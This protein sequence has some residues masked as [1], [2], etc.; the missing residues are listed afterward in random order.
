MSVPDT[1]LQPAL[2]PIA[3]SAEGAWAACS[4][5]RQIADIAR[6]LGGRSRSLRAGESEQRIRE[7][8]GRMLSGSAMRAL[9][10]AMRKDAT[11]ERGAPR[12]I[13]KP[14]PGSMTVSGP[15]LVELVERISH[16]GRE[17]RCRALAWRERMP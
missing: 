15:H 2:R 4:T 14:K 5:R 17:E 16:L 3:D 10:W 13:G 12:S 6:R 11:C 9:T 7:E 1:V 8:H